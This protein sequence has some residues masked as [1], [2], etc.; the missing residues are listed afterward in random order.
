MTDAELDELIADCPKLYHMA[1]RHSW[2]S[3]RQYGLLST[4]ALM[5]LYGIEGAD[6]EQI[7]RRHRPASVPITGSGLPGAVVRDQIP[8]S[9]GGLRKALPARLSPADW[10]A[11]LNS[12]VFFWT[13]LDRLHKLTGAK[14]YR[15]LE[16]DVLE[17]DTRSLVEAH[18]ARVWLCPINSGCTK[19][20][21]H[22]R[23]E[24]AFLRVEKYPYSHW[25]SR[26][27]ATERVVELAV[28]YSVPDIADHVAR[29]VA[30]RGSEELAVIHERES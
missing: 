16:H 9:D 23:D 6:R 17:I 3:I 13:S 15:D 8:M 4:S 18:R 22:P 5:D 12:K 25:R 24:N 26:R 20:F 30:K 27:R 11:L 28:D 29:V 14:T 10:Y 19:P 1:E 7:E 2:P 21:P